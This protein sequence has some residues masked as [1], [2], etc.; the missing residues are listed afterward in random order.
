MKSFKET[1]VPLEESTKPTYPANHKP[2]MRVP[3]GGSCCKNCKFWDVDHK[4]CDN[5]HY[6][7]WSGKKEI[8]A[9]PDEYCSDWWEPK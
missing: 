1:F 3:K 9:P 2:A 6:R 7:E 5:E 8:P 4:H